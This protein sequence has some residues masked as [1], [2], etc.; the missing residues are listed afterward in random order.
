MT[1]TA[2]TVCKYAMRYLSCNSPTKEFSV[3]YDEIWTTVDLARTV[4]DKPVGASASMLGKSDISLRMYETTPNRR[5]HEAPSFPIHPMHDSSRYEMG[6]N[7]WYFVG[8]TTGHM[9]G[10]V[11]G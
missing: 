2:K 8:T 5:A 6:I 1:F 7:K 10:I 11:V 3:S 9:W 4:L